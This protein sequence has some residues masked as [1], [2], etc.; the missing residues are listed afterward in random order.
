MKNP[1]LDLPRTKPYVLE[2][3]RPHV[4]AF[5]RHAST[6]H[7]LDLRMLPLPFV[8]NRQA[9]LL[10]LGLN[11]SY[12]PDSRRLDRDG[13]A[14]GDAIRANLGPKP[15][16]HVHP[17]LNPEFAETSGGRWWRRCFRALIDKGHTA[18]SLA[19]DVLA[20]EFHG[21]RSLNWQPIPYTLPSQH[22]GFELVRRAMQRQ[23]T[24]VLARGRRH[25]DVA[26][27][28]LRNYDSRV[29]LKNARSATISP[30]NCTRRGFALVR[31]ALEG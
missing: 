30:K 5:N 31:K 28:E 25:W 20:V 14:R 6:K 19:R 13:T 3:D 22:F 18:D 27:P 23:A 8:G 2:I 10:V 21:Y 16:G 4:E 29:E 24:I 1:W 15:R 12:Q 11:P 7:R 17:G 26:I 9:P